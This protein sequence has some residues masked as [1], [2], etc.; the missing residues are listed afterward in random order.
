MAKQLVPV[1]NR[2][3]LHYVMQHLAEAGLDEVGV[4]MSPE[5]GGQILEALEDN[6]WGLSFTHIVQE[7]PLGLAQAVKE[8]RPFLGDDPFVMYLG[9]NL[10]GQ[11]LG[12]LISA[13]NANGADAAILLK[14]VDNPQ[15]FGV[16]QVDSAGRVVTLIEKPPVPPSNLALVGAY[17]FSPSID[18][19]IGEIAPSQRGDLEVTDAI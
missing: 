10:I 6:P 8:A 17:V 15:A 4:I 12:E 13:F 2:P 3:V 14:E 19:A 11:G 5:T 1:A 18:A 7:N 16:A 9:D